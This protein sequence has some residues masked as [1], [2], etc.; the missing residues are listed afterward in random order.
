MKMQNRLML[1]AWFVTAS[2]TEAQ[3]MPV[4][5]VTDL[6]TLGGNSY[7]LG[8][9][10][11]GDVVG[12][13]YTS[14]GSIH[15][16]LFSDGL[17]S[18]LGALG[19]SY[20]VASDINDKG[21]IVGQ[22]ENS[23]GQDHAFVYEKGSMTDLGTLGGTESGAGGINN[24][25][26]VV[27]SSMNAAGTTQ[28][29]LYSNGGMTELNTWG[30]GASYAT[31][32]NNGGDIVGWASILPDF[33][34]PEHPFYFDDGVAMPIGSYGGTTGVAN[35]INSAG[36]VVGFGIT[37]SSQ[38]GAFFYSDGV[39]TNMGTLGGNYSIA[40]GLNDKGQ[41]VG[42]SATDGYNNEHAFLYDDK[43]GMLDLNSFLPTN[44]NFV[45]LYQAMDI[46][47]RGEIVGVG[48]LGDGS[49]HAFLMSS[50]HAVDEPSS[51]AI[52][53]IGMVG[54]IALRRRH[55]RHISANN[56]KPHVACAR[57]KQLKVGAR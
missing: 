21:T 4:Y 5:S 44:S 28:A 53:G 16:F 36:D 57:Q 49:M 47:N 54:L 42:K 17:M 18:D 29:F 7:A 2:L 12:Y 30:G 3:A 40:Y 38:M 51:L 22:A 50:V 1:L 41:A 43:F 46:N 52:M 20:S 45:S 14:A 24:L 35:A 32:I 6:G 31:D 55:L 19:G 33:V 11:N 48:Y 13:S 56:R 23:A 9:N 37:T 26:Q 15:A 27:G 34:S 10:N 8:L 25:G 39:F